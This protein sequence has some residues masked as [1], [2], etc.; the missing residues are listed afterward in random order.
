MPTEQQPG[1][2]LL[3]LGDS[4]LPISLF[5]RDSPAPFSSDSTAQSFIVSRLAGEEMKSG[6]DL[7]GRR[8]TAKDCILLAV[9]VQVQ[10]LLLPVIW[11]DRSIY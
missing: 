2:E 6:I 3:Q 8:L 10:Q 1:L 7:S 4:P 11:L 9:L 5:L